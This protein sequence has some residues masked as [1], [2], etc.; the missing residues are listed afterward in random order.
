MRLAGEC[1]LAQS[2][3]EEAFHRRLSPEL[4][5][6]MALYVTLDVVDFDGY[7]KTAEQVA[8]SQKAAKRSIT[9]N[10]FSSS[11]RGRNNTEGRGGRGS[12][13]TGG[14]SN[15]SNQKTP[16]KEEID[17]M[18]QKGM[19][20]ICK[21]QGHRAKECPDKNGQNKGGPTASKADRHTRLQA[22]YARYGIQDSDETL[23]E[24]KPADEEKGN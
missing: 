15:S 7:V 24:D 13:S 16:S 17:E 8:Y 6:G 9:S 21:Q 1:Q 23:K 4:Q 18:Y 22:V 11:A 3:W 2:Q 10:N 5:V 20:F 14:N 19:C 12:S